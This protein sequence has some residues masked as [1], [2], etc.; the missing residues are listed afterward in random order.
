M[1]ILKL[2]N[3][4]ISGKKTVKRKVKQYRRNGKTVKGH[5]RTMTVNAL[6]GEGWFE[7]GRRTGDVA[8][9]EKLRKRERA[10]DR[11]IAAPVVRRRDTWT[12]ADEAELSRLDYADRWYVMLDDDDSDEYVDRATRAAQGNEK[13]TAQL[14]RKQARRYR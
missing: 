1:R 4:W 11:I 6:L 3:N 9:A 10:I 13:R 2:I 12:K 14:E 8:G 5:T 7:Y